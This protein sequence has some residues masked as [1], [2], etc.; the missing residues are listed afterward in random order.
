MK[1]FTASR[2]III[3][4][5]AA[6]ILLIAAALVIASSFLKS[7]AVEPI[8]IAYV[9]DE[10]ITDRE[11]NFFAEDCRSEVISYFYNNCNAE[12]S[13]KFW[14]TEYMGKMPKDQLLDRALEAAVRFKTE[15]IMMKE[16]GI[17]SNLSYSE[18]YKDF[19]SENKKRKKG[20]DFLYGP[21]LY[22][23]KGYF[24]YLHNNR[25]LELK[26]KLNG[27]AD[28]SSEEFENSYE[29]K[30]SSAKIKI[31]KSAAEQALKI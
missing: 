28:Y 9:E 13:D 31:I 6:A 30:R 5:S 29:I 10:P 1:Y 12:Y 16:Q 8:V 7:S 23:E 20:S 25:L 19:Q 15:Q 14:N 21:K 2:K 17:V 22:T 18:F 4:S 27:T 24:D 11:L 26:A 3:V